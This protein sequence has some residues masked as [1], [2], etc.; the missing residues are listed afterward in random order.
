MI[1]IFYQEKNRPT[2]INHQPTL[3]AAQK[4]NPAKLLGLWFFRGTIIYSTG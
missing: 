1:F 2:A 4:K 3:V